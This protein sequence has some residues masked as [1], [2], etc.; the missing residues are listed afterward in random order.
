MPEASH[1]RWGRRAP[2]LST[3]RVAAAANA[4]IPTGMAMKRVEAWQARGCAQDMVLYMKCASSSFVDSYEE[5]AFKDLPNRLPSVLSRDFRRDPGRYEDFDNLYAIHLLY[6]PA[7]YSMR[8]D[9]ST[10]L[11]AIDQRKTPRA[12]QEAAALARRGALADS[13]NDLHGLQVPLRG[14]GVE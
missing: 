6:N 3:R 10:K 12:Y 8:V 1:A 11:L 14:T 2:I 9:E 13:E 5:L 4:N 7:R